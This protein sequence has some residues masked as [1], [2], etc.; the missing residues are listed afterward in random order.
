MSEVDRMR[1]SLGLGSR[2]GKGFVVSGL[3]NTGRGGSGDSKYVPH[4][5]W[6]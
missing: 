5:G 4:M 3:S 1:V 2:V 6:I